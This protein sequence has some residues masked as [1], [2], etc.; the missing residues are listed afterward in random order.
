[1]AASGWDDWDSDLTLAEPAINGTLTATHPSP[2]LTLCRS[3][4]AARSRGAQHRDCGQ[5][6]CQAEP[7]ETPPLPRRRRPPPC[8][9]HPPPRKPLPPAAASPPPACDGYTVTISC[10]SAGAG[11]P[12]RFGWLP[13]AD[14][15]NCDGYST[16]TWPARPD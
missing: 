11:W 14:S 6:H 13:A 4:A 3:A 12:G 9:S 10:R 15:D 2:P 8:R 7:H 16:D 1:M 5:W